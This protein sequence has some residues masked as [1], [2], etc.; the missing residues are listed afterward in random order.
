MLAVCLV[1]SFVLGISA[2]NWGKYDCMNPDA[3]A[4]KSIAKWPPLHPDRFDRPPLH[5]YINNMLINEPSKWV[6]SA[7]VVFGGQKSEAEK[8]RWQVRTILARLLQFAFFSG[9]VALVFV[10]AR[11][12]I[13]LAAARASAFLLATSPSFLLNKVFLSSDITLI[14]WMLASLVAS[15]RILKSGGMRASVWAGLFAGFAAATK[16]NGLAVG[17]AIPLAHFFFRDGGGRWDFLRRRAFWVGGLAAPVGFVLANP[18]SVLDY[19]KFFAD[20][21]YNYKVTPIYDG[22]TGGTGYGAFLS[23]L[24]EVLGWPFLLLAPLLLVLG[25]LWIWKHRASGAFAATVI[26]GAIFALYFWKIGGFPRMESRFV[27]PMA[28]F[29]LLLVASG[30]QWL[31]TWRWAAVVP[32]VLLGGYGIASGFEITRQFVEDPRMA[33]ISWAETHFPKS[34]RIEASTASPAWKWMPGKSLKVIHF[35]IGMDRNQR[36]SE[37][38]KDDPWVQER[39]NHNL[40]LNQ[41]EFFTTEALAKRRSDFI[42]VDSQYLHDRLAAPF[43]EELIAG[44]HGYHVA[45]DGKPPVLP[46]WVFPATPNSVRVRFVILARDP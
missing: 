35:P 7:T 16:Y 15:G 41:P 33:A 26:C 24:P 22:E 34:A 39:L 1:L 36:F 43:L 37:A 19:K 45:F 28:P 18:Y 11:E 20:F 2:L 27:L 21:M 23:A 9:S 4:F 3:T 46:Q 32:A 10:F 8:W 30:W 29:L 13:G 12:H 31:A 38:L 25:L 44:G 5:S 40:A 42:T 14:F 17:L 6:A